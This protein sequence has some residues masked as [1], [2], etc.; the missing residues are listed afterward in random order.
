[1]PV[2]AVGLLL[3]SRLGEPE[4]VPY[5]SALGLLRNLTRQA[6]DALD[7]LDRQRAGVVRLT[8]AADDHAGL[9]RTGPRTARPPVL[10]RYR[11]DAAAYDAEISRAEIGPTPEAEPSRGSGR[12]RGVTSCAAGLR[13]TWTDRSGIEK[14]GL[15]G[16]G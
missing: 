15:R 14:R 5:L 11:F 9:P 13:D 3:L 4:D 2:V 8:A 1:V 12:A 7:A 10:R 6:V 16:R